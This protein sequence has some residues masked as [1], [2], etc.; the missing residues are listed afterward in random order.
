MHH[1]IALLALAAC[2]KDTIG[3][4]HLEPPKP[5]PKPVATKPATKTPEPAKAPEP[6]K[7]PKPPKLTAKLV[8]TKYASEDRRGFGCAGPLCSDTFVFDASY[9]GAMTVEA[10]GG[11]ELLVPGQTLKNGDVWKVDLLDL[12]SRDRREGSP[13]NMVVK[14]PVQLKKGDATLDVEVAIDLDWVIDVGLNGVVKGKPFAFPSDKTS[15][16]T[17]DAIVIA[18]GDAKDITA[19]TIYPEASLA[20]VDLVAVERAGSHLGSSCAYVDERGTRVNKTRQIADKRV[21]VYARRTGRVVTQRTFNG[22]TPPCPETMLASAEIYGYVDTEKVLEWEKSLVKPHPD[23][24][25]PAVM[26]FAALGAPKSF[27]D[28]G[29][30][31]SQL[32]APV[33]ALGA[34]EAYSFT[35]ADI[36]DSVSGT[37]GEG[38]VGVIAI[39]HPRPSTEGGSVASVFKEDFAVVV[40]LGDKPDAQKLLDLVVSKWPDVKAMMSQRL[41]GFEPQKDKIDDT[42]PHQTAFFIGGSIYLVHKTKT[43]ACRRTDTSLLC[44]ERAPVEGSKLTPASILAKLK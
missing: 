43:S 32:L 19:N 41:P 34:R 6:P 29:E 28:G 7:P 18:A 23:Q 24:F 8:G 1:W 25:D 21:T 27:E 4:Q 37:L 16:L 42:I 33:V 2:G 40:Q 17:N 39:R 13:S 26:P 5:E 14:I 30:V 11:V 9:V 36:L 15:R 38:S 31:P 22:D 10:E 3:E 35:H 12:V 20:E 44:V